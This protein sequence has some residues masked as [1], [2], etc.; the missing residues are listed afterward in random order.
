MFRGLS[1]EESAYLAGF[2]TEQDKKAWNKE[3]E[4]DFS[5]GGAG[6]DLLHEVDALIEK[7]KVKSLKVTRPR[8][9]P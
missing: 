5:A 2:I 9:K 6:M 8:G 3:I 7:D 1:S 4:R